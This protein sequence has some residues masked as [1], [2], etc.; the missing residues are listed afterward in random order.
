MCA[1]LAEVWQRLYTCTTMGDIGQIYFTWNVIGEGGY[2][3]HTFHGIGETRRNIYAWAGM[4]DDELHNFRFGWQTFTA[5][6]L[7][8]S[9]CMVDNGVIFYRCAGKAEKDQHICMCHARQTG[10]W[11]QVWTFR[12][13]RDV[14]LKL[15]KIFCN[16]QD[17]LTMEHR[18][19]R[20][21]EEAS[22]PETVLQILDANVRHNFKKCY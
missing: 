1:S 15:L 3:I 12:L 18:A 17:C 20:V 22:V 9:T 13:V 6:S 8:R 2:D 10:S 16:G 14:L 11:G 4:G 5:R 7:Y 21:V 19:S